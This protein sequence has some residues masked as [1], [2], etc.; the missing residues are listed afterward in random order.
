M[1][2]V[3]PGFQANNTTEYA[4]IHIDTSI[5][6][7]VYLIPV[8]GTD[9]LSRE[10]KFYHSYDAFQAYYGNNYADHYAFEIAF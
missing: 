10:L 6:R 8:Y 4:I 5:Y 9:F 3:R 1:W 2:M 7:A